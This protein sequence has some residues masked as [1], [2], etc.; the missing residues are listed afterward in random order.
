MNNDFDVCVIGSGA[1]GGPVALSLAKAGY[2]VV[3]LEKGPWFREVDLRKDELACCRRYTYTPD[4]RQEPHVVE[5]EDDDGRWHQSTTHRSGWNF[6]NGNCV[7]G[8]SN[9][10][11]GYFH[12]LK[13]VDF[14]L[15]E[16][17]GPFEG[18]NV[19]DWPITYD[20]LEPYYSLVEEAVGISGSIRPHPQLEPRSRQDF[21]YPALAEHPIAGMIDQAA[22]RLGYHAFPTP[23]AI[24]P[25]AAKGRQG[26]S[27]NGGRCG[28][29]GCSTGAKGSSRAAL[30]DQAVATGRCEIR[31]HAMV[32]RLVSDPSGRLTAVEW[33]DKEGQFQQLRAGIYVVACQ[34]IESARLLLRSVG[35]RHSDGLANGSGQ[36]GRNLL[37]AGGGAA[38]GRLVYAQFPPAQAEVL[39]DSRTFINRAIQDWY[40][41]N[42]PELGPPAKGGTID[43]V[44]RHPAPIARAHDQL[45]GP[46]GMRW[47]LPLKR[48]MEAHFRE[49][50][51]IKVEAFCDWMPVDDCSVRLDPE[52]KDRWGLP[53][54]RVRTGYHVQNL[55][56]G[57]YLA[58]KGADVLRQMGAQ[59]VVSF[60]SG[61]PPT[62]LVAG[63]CRFGSDPATSVLDRDCR[64]HEVENLFV[65]DGSFMPTGGS[66]PYT[67]TI[68]ANAFRV[69]DRIIQQLGGS[70]T[71]VTVSDVVGRTSTV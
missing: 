48:R 44:H 51:Y 59:D 6:W 61:T 46:E 66:V 2:S 33:F 30:L 63:T 56:V 10:M 23:R 54:A 24:L 50:S 25:F 26:C 49:G 70:R 52:I 65:T 32:S 38:S 9:F 21:P 14:H 47:G 68:Y 57:W 67:W 22:E 34:A 62:N 18:A 11:S 64:A 15:L 12:R 19:A 7:G 3:V 28:S 58:A 69:A 1:G 53:V 42:D 37:F 8:S 29:S 5:T 17:F 35:P 55:K 4:P 43:F 31:P 16:T 71:R 13:P 40:E 27:Y 20:D 36:V 60:A 41:I 45:Q 39:K